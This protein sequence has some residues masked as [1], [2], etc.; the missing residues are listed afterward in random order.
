MNGPMNPDIRPEV[1]VEAMPTSE[2]PPQRPLHTRILQ[3]IGPAGAMGVTQLARELDADVTRLG[4]GGFVRND[5]CLNPR[6]NE[7]AVSM[8][9]AS[10]G[11]ATFR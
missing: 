6:E 8:S 9:D 7:I 11:R 4:H 2:P 10:R 5:A 3:A 1:D